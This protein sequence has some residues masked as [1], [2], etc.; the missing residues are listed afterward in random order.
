MAAGA[1]PSGYNSTGIPSA[2]SA[3]PK[4]ALAGSSTKPKKTVSSSPRQSHRGSNSGVR[5]GASKT[6][7]NQAKRNK[8]QR[9]N[10]SHN[11]GG[12][13]AGGLTPNLPSSGSGGGSAEQDNKYVYNM[14]DLNCIINNIEKNF[15]NAAN[16]S[17]MP[18]T[19]TSSFLKKFED[20]MLSMKI[21][22][23]P[24]FP[25]SY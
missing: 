6:P 13:G 23:N 16:F 22:Q 5:K 17:S 1:G 19:P 9:L 21:G 2:S 10:K 8:T 11:A 3:Q 25:V 20:K 15:Q 24:Q 7:S 18:T 14:R 4:S 12:S